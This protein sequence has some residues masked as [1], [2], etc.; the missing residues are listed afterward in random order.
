[1]EYLLLAAITFLGI[2][3]TIRLVHRTDKQ[4]PSPIVELSN[5][6]QQDPPHK[7]LVDDRFK[8]NKVE[9]LYLPLHGRSVRFTYTGMGKVLVS[10]EGY[11]IHHSKID[12]E[13]HIFKLRGIHRIYEHTT[14]LA[15]LMYTFEITSQEDLLKYIIKT[16]EELD[17]LHDTDY[18]LKQRLGMDQ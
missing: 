7:G 11:Y 13:L 18:L 14:D 12:D 16:I 17:E 15:H 3:A 2:Y 6:P 9:E 8:V 1:M 10:T 4:T 5:P